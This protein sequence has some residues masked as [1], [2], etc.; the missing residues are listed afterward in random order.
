MR[1]R[2]TVRLSIFETN[3]VNYYLQIDLQIDPQI[4]PQID[5]HTD[6]AGH[7]RTLS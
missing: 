1:I 2:E 7:S 3:V 4:D 5:L 6:T